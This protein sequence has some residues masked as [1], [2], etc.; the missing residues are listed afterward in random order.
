MVS[1]ELPVAFLDEPFDEVA[2]FDAIRR[3]ETIGRLVSSA[4]WIAA[5]QHQL[6]RP[7]D[8][9]KPGL[10]PQSAADTGRCNK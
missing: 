1:W 3:A 5:V 10:R 7:I 4:D 6:H 9:R 2:N 8:R